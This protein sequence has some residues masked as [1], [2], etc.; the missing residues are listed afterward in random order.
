MSKTSL[1]FFNL[2]IQISKRFFIEEITRHESC[3]SEQ[4]LEIDLPSTEQA[5]DDI[6]EEIR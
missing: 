5:E 3:C 4:D 1:D 2:L 6:E